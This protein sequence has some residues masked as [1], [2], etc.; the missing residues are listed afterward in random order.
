MN[1]ALL[2]HPKRRFWRTRRFRTL[3]YQVLLACAVLALAWGIVRNTAKNLEQR[4]ISSGFGFLENEAG[5]GIAEAHFLPLLRGGMSVI[6]L[7]SGLG[8]AFALLLWQWMRWRGQR[9]NEHTGVIVCIVLLVFVVPAL[10]FYWFGE[11]VNGVVYDES[12]SYGVAL[13]TGLLNTI[14]LAL[15][16]CVLATMIGILVGLG[17]LSSNWLVARLTAFYVDIF[18]NIPLLLQIFFWYFA[19]L[20]RLPSVQQSLK[21][22]DWFTLNNRG[23]IFP[24]LVAQES[25]GEFWLA[26]VAGLGALYF[27]ARAAREHQASTGRQRPLF[28]P[29]LGLL[30]LPPVAVCVLLGFPYETQLPVL[31]AFNYEG[32]IVLTPEF[33]SLLVALTMY[34][35]AFIAEI[36]RSGLLAVSRGQRE[37]ASSIGLPASKSLRLVIF[38][39]ALRVIIPPLTNQYLNLTKNS[40]LGV[41][42]AYPELVS[43]SGTTLNQTGQA[44]EVIALSM[45]AYL[46]F[47]LLI[48]LGMNWYNARIRLVGY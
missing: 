16:G 5:F 11:R 1:A 26:L 34:T 19:V 20:R 14:K 24:E 21:F 33:G 28:V 43:V 3:I 29:G 40:S 32:G 25:A 45:L 27:W 23:L 46:F 48:S 22:G 39:Q 8:W 38:P 2:P 7:I 9:L 10:A 42:I 44:L 37:A 36:I 30:I 17:R 41:A 15:V 31:H 47:S 6:L 12:K 18:R 4:G 35:A 13:A